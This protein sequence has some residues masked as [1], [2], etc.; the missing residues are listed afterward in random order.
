MAA[1]RILVDVVLNALRVLQHL[2]EAKE[3]WDQIFAQLDAAKQ[4][5]TVT[6]SCGRRMRSSKHR[7]TVQAEVDPVGRLR[8]SRRE[9]HCIV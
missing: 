3:C 6:W 1:C 5:G 8:A 7:R 4:V 2:F 9:V